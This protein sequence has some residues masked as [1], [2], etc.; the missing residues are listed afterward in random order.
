MVEPATAKPSSV[1]I[2]IVLWQIIMP[3]MFPD[4]APADPRIALAEVLAG[5]AP[6]W[7]TAPSLLPQEWLELARAEQ[8]VALVDWRLREGLPGVPE[9]V[10]KT[11]ADATRGEVAQMMVRQA[12]A[13]RVL[14]RLALAGQP[15]LLLKG[16][17]LA[18]WAYPEPHLRQ[19]QD[20]DLLFATRD[21]AM[22]A[23]TLLAED[24][25]VVRQHFGDAASREFLCVRPHPGA[26]RVEFDMH[27]GLSGKP[28]FAER[29]TFAEML[30][31]CLPLPRLA[32]T[33]RGLGIAHACIHACLH[34]AGDLSNGAGNRL[35]WL[36]DLNQLALRMD[37]SD[38]E[39]LQAL[40]VD[41]GLAGICADALAE[42]ATL[43]ATPLP[44]ATMSALWSACETESLDPKRMREWSYFQ[45]QNLRALPDWGARLRWIWQRLFPT[46]D[47]REDVGVAGSGLVLDRFR[48][49]LHQ[50]RR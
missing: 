16:S 49:A 29:L 44:D 33:A 5:R 28:V 21:S 50:L 17:A 7:P 40:A 11:F 4:A 12:E 37:M 6:C 47:Y 24:G 9:P 45:R 22:D 35:K 14:G 42:A 43:F 19:C 46:S 31:A 13:R 8:V 20:V 39:D 2:S 3:P 15:A 23:A 36:F 25:Y 30:A 1:L 18:Y 41:R 32:P 48:R 10:R 26:S 38:W 27:W 34:R